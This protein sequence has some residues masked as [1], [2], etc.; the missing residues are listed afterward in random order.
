MS[1]ESGIIYVGLLSYIH[2]EIVS[3][4]S[5][6][7]GMWCGV[8]SGVSCSVSCESQYLQVSSHMCA[9]RLS[10]VIACRVAACFVACLESLKLCM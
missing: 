9:S 4:S 5:V 1:W 2:I 10:R 8:P 3:C 6:S 7:S